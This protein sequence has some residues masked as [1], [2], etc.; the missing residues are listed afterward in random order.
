[1][2]PCTMIDD[3]EGQRRLSKASDPTEI[4]KRL[5]EIIE[6]Y[7]TSSDESDAESEKIE[8]EVVIVGAECSVAVLPN[9]EVESDPNVD[10]E[11]EDRVEVS[12]NKDL[13][14]LLSDPNGNLVISDDD[15]KFHIEKT[16]GINEQNMSM[17]VAFEAFEKESAQDFI[18]SLTK[19]LTYLMELSTVEE[20]DDA[21]L[22]FASNF[23]SCEYF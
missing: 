15:Q 4:E 19:V 3:H 16:T 6:A 2:Q 14:D 18:Q 12:H 7:E 1:M 11:C 9:A 21:L 5:P 23:C 20:V 8:T 22:Q 13:D 17:K 10:I